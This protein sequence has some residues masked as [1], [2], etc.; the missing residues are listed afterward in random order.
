[1]KASKT[2]EYAVE[3][4]N[5]FAARKSYHK[6]MSEFDLK[7]KFADEILESGYGVNNGATNLRSIFKAYGIDE[8]KTY[9]DLSSIL[10]NSKC[11]YI[12]NR[13]ISYLTK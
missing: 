8:N 10:F 9:K 5:Q 12:E 4:I 6:L 1:M 2:Q 7:P 11:D 13:L 3:T